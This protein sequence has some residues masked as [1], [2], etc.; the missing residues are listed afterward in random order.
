MLRTNSKIVR[1]RVRS[2]IL[3]NSEDIVEVMDYEGVPHEHSKDIFNYIWSDFMEREGN[4]LGR[5]VS[6]QDGFAQFGSGLPWHIFDYYYNV[7]AVK[8]VGDILDET[9]EERARFS[10]R[11]AEKLMSYLIFK[12]VSKF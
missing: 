6:Y 10:E 12:E 11:D 5:G 7:E 3:E 1:E 8:L 9:E 4:Y 2:Y